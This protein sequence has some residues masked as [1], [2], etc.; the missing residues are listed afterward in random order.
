[1][2]KLALL[3]ESVLCQ[4]NEVTVSNSAERSLGHWKFLVGY[5]TFPTPSQIS[6]SSASLLPAGQSPGQFNLKISASKQPKK[7][8]GHKMWP[9][10]NTAVYRF[11]LNDGNTIR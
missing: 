6:R 11:Y 5:W 9:A 1:M 3:L 4:H 10:L 8:A 7:R 2:S